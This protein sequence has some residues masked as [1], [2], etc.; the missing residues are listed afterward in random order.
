MQLVCGGLD[1]KV[2]AVLNSQWPVRR[3]LQSADLLISTEVTADFPV[4]S[5][6]EIARRWKADS[7]FVGAEKLRLLERV[8]CGNL[9]ASIAARVECSV[10]V[11]RGPVR[12]VLELSEFDVEAHNK[13]KASL[14]IAS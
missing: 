5:V 8:F 12:R 4:T 11:V 13:D 7:V 9:V 1:A 14:R 6:I 2:E 3:E 10:E